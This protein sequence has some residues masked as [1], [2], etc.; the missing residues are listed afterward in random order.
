MNWEQAHCTSEF[1]LV[2][3]FEL[4][5][6]INENRPI[7]FQTLRLMSEIPGI[8]VFISLSKSLIVFSWALWKCSLTHYR[9]AEARIKECR[10]KGRLVPGSTLASREAWSPIR[11][12]PFTATDVGP[13]EG[14]RTRQSLQVR[15]SRSHRELWALSRDSSQRHGHIQ[16]PRD[17]PEPEPNPSHSL[18]WLERS[19]TNRQSMRG[20]RRTRI[21]DF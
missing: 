1:K 18:W 10:S 17:F 14:P 6:K 12:A 2:I 20:R 8:S 13:W 9:L 15:Q 3:F 21:E 19:L 4:A 7:R 5:R 11:R 16:V